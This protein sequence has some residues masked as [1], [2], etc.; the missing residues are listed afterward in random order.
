MDNVVISS[1]NLEDETDT[2][3]IDVLFNG[4]VQENYML[5][6]LFAE[7]EQMSSILDETLDIG[8]I[9]GENLSY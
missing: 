6:G 7:K 2:E 5:A 9:S 8:K 4:A 1:I 3:G